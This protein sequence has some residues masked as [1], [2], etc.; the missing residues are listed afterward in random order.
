MM[1]TKLF[2][3]SI[4]IL[5]LLLLATGAITFARYRQSAPKRYA[6]SVVKKITT[7]RSLDLYNELTTSTKQATDQ[8]DFNSSIVQIDVNSK[9][10]IALDSHQI[11]EATKPVKHTVHQLTY[12]VTNT[13]KKAYRI[14]VYS[15]KE[16]GKWKLDDLLYTAGS[17][18]D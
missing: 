18:T 6:D 15:V 2:R 8:T 7:A 17:V 4:P 10:S 16:G 5:A 3:I 14:D 11:I 9:S 13:D 1:K 12:I